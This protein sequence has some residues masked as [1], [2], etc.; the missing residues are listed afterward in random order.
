V[1]LRERMAAMAAGSV[2]VG[3]TVNTAQ[4]GERRDGVFVRFTRA[5]RSR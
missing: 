2:V 3:E 5:S 4:F 1:W